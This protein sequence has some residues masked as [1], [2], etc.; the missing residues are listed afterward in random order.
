MNK[1][2]HEFRNFDPHAS[3]FSPKVGLRDKQLRVVPLP[4]KFKRFPIMAFEATRIITSAAQGAEIDGISIQE[5]DETLI[6]IFDQGIHFR[7][8]LGAESRID[9]GIDLLSRIKGQKFEEYDYLW[10]VDVFSQV[11]LD[12]LPENRRHYKVAEACLAPLALA[13][14]IAIDLTLSFI[15]IRDVKLQRHFYLQAEKFAWRLKA[16]PKFGPQSPEDLSRKG[17]N[18]RHAA[19]NSL[20]VYA[21]E[22]YHAR[23][24]KEK[25]KYLNGAATDLTP[26]VEAKAKS[27]GKTYSGDFE[28]TVYNWL[29][30][31]PKNKTK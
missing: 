16:I 8:E 26:M 2:T 21:R 20:K 13:L 29:R 9:W 24:G 19:S 30:D 22:L 31:K 6:I 27:M 15:E 3:S 18:V 12:A 1:F 23:G 11:V 10:I 17:A 7:D 14:L 28:K 25:Y 5:W 4:A